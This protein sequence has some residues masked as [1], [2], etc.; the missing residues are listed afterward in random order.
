MAVWVA[1]AVALIATSFGPTYYLS[2]MII[3]CYYLL[4]AIGWNIIAGYTGL[5]SFAQVAFA[6]L[7]GY[8]SALSISFSHF[9]VYF[10]LF[11]GFAFVAATAAVLGYGS[12]KLT[13][14][15]MALATIAFSEGF[16]QFLYADVS[17]TGGGS[18]FFT[19]PLIPNGTTFRLLLCVRRCLCGRSLPLL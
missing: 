10:G 15:Y 7:A 6:N 13:G 11:V 17:L 8:A 14:T 4:L 19:I 9:P 1:L 5:P 2:I 16:R 18:G 12:V 3:I